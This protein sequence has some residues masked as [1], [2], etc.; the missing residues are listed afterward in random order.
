MTKRSVQIVSAVLAFVLVLVAVLTTCLILIPREETLPPTASEGTSSSG[1]DVPMPESP[2]PDTLFSSGMENTSKVGFSAEYLGTVERHIPEVSDEGLPQYPLYGQPF[3]ASESEKQAIIDENNELT[4]SDSTYDGMDEEGNLYLGGVPTGKKLYKHTAAA[5]MYEGELSDDEPAVVKRMTIRSRSGGNHITGLY[6]PAGEVVKVE[7]GASDLEKTGGLKI[8]IGQAL[9][10]GGANN[11]WASRDFNRMPVILNTM[12]VKTTTAYVG[13]F[14]GGPVYVQPVNASAKPTFTVTV[15]GAVP[16]SHFILGYTT[17]EE[18]E[19][20][21]DSTA[22]YFDLEVWDDGVRHSGP[23]SRAENFDFAELTAAAVLW[24]KIARVSN[25]VPAGSGGETGIIFLYDPFIAAGSMVA[26]VGRHSVNCPPQ[27]LTAALDAESAVD[28]ASDNFW[29]CIHEFNHHFQRFGFAPGDEVTNNAVS[30]VEYSLFT[31]ISSNR[32][33][34][35]ANE[36]SYAVGWNRYTNPSWSLRQTIAD[37]SA[38]SN[39]D[40]YANLL[41]AFGQDVFIRATQAGNGSGGA[42]AWYRAVSDV[43][44]ND[45]TYYFTDLLHQ[46]VSADV[47]SEY[48]LKGYPVFVPVASVYQTGRSY[49]VDGE[50]YYSRTAQ[51]YGIETGKD[52]TLDLKNNVVLPDGFTYTVKNITAPEYGTLREQSDGVYVYSPDPA[53]RGSGKMVATLAIEK[54]DG[55]FDVQDVELVIELQQKQYRPTMLE[56]TVYTYDTGDMYATAAEAY[57]AGYA[58]YKE[59][60]EEDNENRVENGNAEIWEPDPASNAVMEIRGKFRIGGSGRYRVALRGRRSAALYLSRDGRTFE[61]AARLD[62]TTNSPSFDLGDPAHYRDYD[63]AKGDWVYFKAVLLV[64]RSNAFVGVGLGKFD[65]EGEVSVSYLN[66]YRNSYER[67]PFVSDY[68]YTHDYRYEGE[69]YETEQRLVETNYS[70]WEENYPID[71]LFD[72]DNTN[73]IHSDRTPVTAE[74]P[75]ELTVDLGKTVRANR[76][77][78]YGEPSRQYQPKDFCLYGGESLDDLE[79]I[80]DVTDAPRTGADVVADFAERE[81]RYYKLVVTDTWATGPKYIAFRRAAFSYALPDGAWRSPD[82]DM[83]VYKGNWTVAG[84]LATFGH[85]YVGENASM[86]FTFTG[87]RL[88]ILSQRSAEYGAF[89]VLIDGAPAAALPRAG[90]GVGIAFLSEELPAGSHTVVVRSREKFNVD[91]VV[92][93]D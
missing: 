48:A 7:I 24:D 40:S 38:N 66:A 57:E 52:F 67:D 49:T 53:H 47:L 14:F 93:W 17:E 72:A 88:A 22:P 78:I 35:N 36:G 44:H 81:L 25:A 15:S 80:S 59:K 74:N 86:E 50:K 83:F 43:T 69:E 21:K 13:S 41:H 16:Y 82:E 31:R 19:Q 77:T 23:K 63:F 92:L 62:N 3:S 73:F 1:P 20:N 42:D 76:L 75:F 84:G 68:F 32:S 37:R 26:F 65:G 2:Y 91:S 46:T 12:T 33:L 29:G 71:A 51:P 85:F 60:R 30:L 58:G 5:G 18:F 39:L 4:A 10:N 6:A 54:S 56:R 8:Y 55:A 70:P 9:A 45:M 34:G 90:E 28:N 61:E 87:T 11:I 64:D 27:C 89:E 79:L